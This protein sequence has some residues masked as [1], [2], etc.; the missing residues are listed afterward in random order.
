MIWFVVILLLLNLGFTIFFVAAYYE[1]INQNQRDINAIA[2]RLRA[3]EGT[4]QA[5]TA[6]YDYRIRVME[7]KI[8]KGDDTGFNVEHLIK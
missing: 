8:Y 2:T 6:A 1:K 7:N 5:W 3:V 4:N